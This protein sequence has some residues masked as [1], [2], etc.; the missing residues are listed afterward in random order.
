M[1]FNKYILVGLLAL[2]VAGIAYLLTPRDAMRAYV[3]SVDRMER[4]RFTPAESVDIAMA[5]KLV[6][7]EPPRMLAPPDPQP[8]QLLF[9][10]TD[11]D[12][13]RL[14]GP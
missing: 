1:K 9:P 12:L 2:A 10:P 4:K 6:T 11:E 14:S 13:A 3:N 5:M 8:P 7:H